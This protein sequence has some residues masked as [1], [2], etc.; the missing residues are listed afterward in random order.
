MSRMIRAN[1]AANHVQGLGESDRAILCMNWYETSP[2]SCGS[3]RWSAPS[4]LA[5]TCTVPELQ[6]CWDFAEVSKTGVGHIISV[7]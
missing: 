2:V 5:Y 6:R 1:T 3:M 7:K 4:D